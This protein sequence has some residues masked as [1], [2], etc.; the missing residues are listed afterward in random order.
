MNPTVTGFIAGP[1]ANGST[2]IFAAGIAGIPELDRAYPDERHEHP[3]GDT[4]HL[5]PPAMCPCWPSVTVDRSDN[6]RPVRVVRHH[7]LDGETT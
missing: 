1:A 4:G 3:D 2:D 5:A 7:R 6:K